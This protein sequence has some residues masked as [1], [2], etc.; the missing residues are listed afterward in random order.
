M[1]ECDNF[2]ILD[3]NIANLTNDEVLNYFQ[4][5]IEAKEK[6]FCVTLNIDIL[7]CAYLS[8]EFFNVLKTANLIFADGMPLV[9]LSKLKGQPLKERIAGRKIV[10]DLC[11]ISND[12]GYKI[13][14]LGAAQGVADC[15]KQKL[16]KR[17]PNIQIV[18]TY[19]PSKDELCN[20]ESNIKIIEAINNSGAEILFVA[21]GAPKQEM[22]I[23]NNLDALN[24]YIYIPCGGSIDFIA[25]VQKKCPEWIGNIGFE[26]LY[27]LSS[28]PK[29]LFRRYIINDLPFLMRLISIEKR[30]ETVRMSRVLYNIMNTFNYIIKGN[31]D[32]NLSLKEQ[33]LLK[34][35][36]QQLSEKR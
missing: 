14:M 25:G 6:V 8:R 21:L 28:A 13:F 1:L 35:N 32:S 4:T 9:W 36:S 10:Y 29:R 15:A 23:H 33:E 30:E 2:K 22:W 31:I 12:K 3:I 17:M 16:E 7:R 24:S 18:G 11:K 34:E 19:S 27:R 26:W 20:P 5:K